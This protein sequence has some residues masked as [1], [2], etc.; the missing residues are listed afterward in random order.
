MGPR[1]ADRAAGIAGVGGMRGAAIEVRHLRYFLA[2]SEELHFRRAAERL[3]MAQ[4]PLSEAIRRLE[5]RLGVELLTRTSR[6]VSMTEAGHAFA[7]EARKVLASL[8]LAV[9][10]A[11]RA[12]GGGSNLRIGCTPYLP[13]E[14]LVHFLARLQEHHPLLRP[15]VAH[16]VAD[17]QIRRLQRGELDLGIFPGAGD[18]TELLTEPLFEGEP[19]AAFLN[20]DH[21]LARKAALSPADLADQTLVSFWHA[22]NPALAAW[23][24]EELRRLG[25]RPQELHEPGT[26]V[27]DWILAVAAG[28]GIALLESSARDVADAGTLIVRRPLD[29]PIQMPDTVLAWHSRQPTQLRLLSDEIRTLTRTLHE[30]TRT[31]DRDLGAWTDTRN[32]GPA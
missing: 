3:H 24:D 23:L 14:L 25:C 22:A 4:P 15:R 9:A 19:V 30:T 12:G 32:G 13:I 11:R 17:E 6:A 7:A 1:D 29:P 16:M 28:A 21:P 20:L 26:D 8:D 2:V 27:R 10:E 31:A 5:E 18:V